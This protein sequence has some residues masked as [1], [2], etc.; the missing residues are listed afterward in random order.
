MIRTIV[1]LILITLIACKQ[2]NDQRSEYGFDTKYKLE[3]PKRS[4]VQNNID[5]LSEIQLVRNEIFAR[6]GREF[7]T[8]KYN[9]YFSKY[10]WYKIN[11]QYSD[12]LLTKNDQRDIIILIN[13]ENN[14]DSLSKNEID[15]VKDAV[16]LIKQFRYNKI[17]TSITSF[18]F[19]NSDTII[20]TIKTIFKNIDDTIIVEYCWQVKDSCFWNFKY[21]N[22]F[23]FYESPL[24]EYEKVD[25]WI[26][27]ALAIRNCVFEFKEKSE[28]NGIDL[29]TAASCASYFEKNVS[30]QEF[31]KY[32][33]NSVR[34]VVFYANEEMGP[35]FDFWYE[36]LN[37]F[38]PYYRP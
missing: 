27:L 1:I 9:I 31:E 2:K 4:V 33:K 12:S 29:K 32:I 26:T 6:Y 17:D 22:P 36:P 20:D 30:Q 11:K 34:Q 37:K 24:F 3:L 23:F 21:K 10:D 38:V 28:F 19:V 7:K 13:Y 35:R 5:L 8:D 15:I 14:L 25:M 16:E 18:G